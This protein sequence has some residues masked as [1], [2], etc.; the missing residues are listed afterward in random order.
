MKIK[1]LACKPQKI[2]LPV[3][4]L[5]DFYHIKSFDSKPALCLRNPLDAWRVTFTGFGVLEDALAFIARR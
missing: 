4:I 3:K 5:C 1:S 2:E